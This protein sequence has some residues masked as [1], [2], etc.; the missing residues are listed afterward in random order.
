MIYLLY[1]LEKQLIQAH[2]TQLKKLEEDYDSK[3][4][5]HKMLLKT[6]LMEQ[7][8]TVIAQ[9]KAGFNEELKVARETQLA[10]QL[11]EVEKEAGF[12]KSLKLEQI[13]AQISAIKS[14]K[15]K[16]IDGDMEKYRRENEKIVREQYM[17][18]YDSLK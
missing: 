4:E 12:V 3:I 7:R 18:L 8:E 6:S 16:A 2:N 5:M 17:N 11:Q 10:K 9:I 1:R 14:E 15:M 13:D